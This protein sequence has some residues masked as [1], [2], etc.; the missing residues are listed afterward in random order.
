MQWALFPAASTFLLCPPAVADS[1]GPTE[2]FMGPEEVKQAGRQAAQNHGGRGRGWV[3]D[4]NDHGTSFLLGCGP[5]GEGVVVTQIE[6]QEGLWL[7][8]NDPS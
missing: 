7:R 8:V 4:Q 2:R 5:G 6:G 3:E 1:V